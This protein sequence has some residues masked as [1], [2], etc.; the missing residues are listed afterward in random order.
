MALLQFD[1]PYVAMAVLMDVAQR[2]PGRL[3]TDLFLARKRPAGIVGPVV[4]GA[5]RASENGLLSLTGGLV[6][7]RRTPSPFNRTSSVDELTRRYRHV[8]PA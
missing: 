4:D 1:E 2:E 6:N 8:V 7:E 5:D 3:P